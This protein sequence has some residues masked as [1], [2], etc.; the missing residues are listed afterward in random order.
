MPFYA[1]KVAGFD[2]FLCIA[3]LDRR[4]LLQHH[5]GLYTYL[6]PALLPP[7]FPNPLVPPVGHNLDSLRGR[8]CS[9][10]KFC[11]YFPVQAH[12]RHMGL[13]NSSLKLHQSQ[14]LRLLKCGYRNSARSDDSVDAHPGASATANES[15]QE[16][17]SDAHVQLW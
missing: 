13:Y 4:A 3:F 7:H 2:P 8:I 6:D 9:D 12:P 16:A 5:A 11:H 17:Q 1:T 10:L 15:H 14:C